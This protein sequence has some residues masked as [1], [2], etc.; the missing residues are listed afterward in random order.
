MNIRPLLYIAII[1]WSLMGV[2]QNATAQ[3]APLGQ[4][5]DPTQ[6]PALTRYLGHASHWNNDTLVIPPNLYDR[7]HSGG[8]GISFFRG[9]E[10]QGQLPQNA[11]RVL[12]FRHRIDTRAP[13]RNDGSNP[14]DRLYAG[15]LWAGL[16]THYQTRN[17]W[18]IS[19]G[20]DLAWTGPDSGVLN[21]HNSLHDLFGLA[22]LTLAQRQVDSGLYLGLTIE[23]GHELQL[24]SGTLR[25]FFELQAGVETLVRVGA[26]VTF[27]AAQTGGLSTR[28]PISGSRVEAIPPRTAQGW[29][30]MFGADIAYVETSVF[31][32]ENR[33]PRHEQIRGRARAGLSYHFP[34]ARLF[35][36]MTYLSE[37]FENQPEGQFIG[38]ISFDRNF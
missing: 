9:P 19:A 30:G 35:Y 15:T 20:A 31:F 25:P 26:D 3:N 13:S 34:A 8:M 1:A 5:Y 16:H 4:I 27:G 33:G 14:N 2:A 21:L 10:W 6:S 29:S 11:G 28:D 37:E 18:D 7:W 24:Q 17:G 36:G 22:P 38:T 32:P 23:A 12:E